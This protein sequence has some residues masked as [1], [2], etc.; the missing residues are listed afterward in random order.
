MKIPAWMVLLGVSAFVCISAALGLVY[1]SNQSRQTLV[2][3]DYYE[4]GLHL[5]E[6]RL[7]EAGFDSLKLHLALHVGAD[8]L[9]LEGHDGVPLDSAT[10]SH[11]KAYQVKLF[12]QRPDDPGADRELILGAEFVTSPGNLPRWIAS[13]TPLRKGRWNC[14]IVFDDSVPRM[15]HSFPYNAGG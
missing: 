10:L 5:N 9:V 3:S 6:Q 8:S 11:L 1:V 13:T 14:R 7:R 15:E 2:R 4:A 12:L